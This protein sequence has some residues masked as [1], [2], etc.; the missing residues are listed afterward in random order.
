MIDV[1]EDRWWVVFT[2]ERKIHFRSRKAALETARDI[3]WY[4]RRAVV[5]WS[6]RGCNH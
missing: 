5:G 3:R 6:L 2:G 1:Q 4:G